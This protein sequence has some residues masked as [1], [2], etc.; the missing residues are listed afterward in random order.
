MHNRRIIP[1]ILI[2][3]LMIVVL[4]DVRTVSASALGA[5]EL[6]IRSL[7]PSLFPLL[8]LSIKLNSM[9]AGVKIPALG[10]LR[11]FTGIP[12][13]S[14]T[15]LLLGLTSGYP[16]GAQMID[17]SYKNNIIPKE[18]A[19]RMLSFCNNA[20]PAFLIGFGSGIFTSSAAPW[21]LWAAPLRATDWDWAQTYFPRHLR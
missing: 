15:L 20:G 9:L 1:I 2:V 16:V 5:I 6:C 10:W 3:F 19:R 11:R 14:E 7:I 4:L 8:L 18:T 12:E 17:S 13:G 21:L